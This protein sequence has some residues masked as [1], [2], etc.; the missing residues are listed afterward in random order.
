MK[1]SF[2]I[3]LDDTITPTGYRYS[4]V[5]CEFGSY[6]YE[7]L[8]RNAPFVR[9]LVLLQTDIDLKLIKTQKFHK[10]RF[11][12]SLVLTYKEICKKTGI[13]PQREIERE[14]KKIGERVFDMKYYKDN[15]IEGVEETLEFL[16][17]QQDDIT[18]LTMGDEKV[19]S[20][21]IKTLNLKKYFKDN[22]IIVPEK[23]KQVYKTLGKE[24]QSLYMIG[25]SK[26]N[27]INHSVKAGWNAIY[28]PMPG[29]T[30][31]YDQNNEEELTEEE[32]KRVIELKQFKEIKEKY[33]EIN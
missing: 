8:G 31:A 20:D 1:K 10:T 19:Q 26:R 27:D 2:F 14:V 18:L 28:I 3:D 16:I 6:L 7:K 4:Q 15:Y 23:K 21:K 11:P 32:L 13:K 5:V 29:G 33:D 24:I 17:A 30:W 22:I 25:D 9:D 12:Y